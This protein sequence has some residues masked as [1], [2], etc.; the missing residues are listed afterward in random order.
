MHGGL[1]CP[2]G[3]TRR[4]NCVSRQPSSRRIVPYVQGMIALDWYEST[5]RVLRPPIGNDTTG[6]FT[7]FWLKNK[8]GQP[9]LWP[10]PN[11]TDGLGTPMY[12]FSI[13]EVQEY[14]VT[15]VAA[16]LAGAANMKGLWFDDT[17]WLA[18]NDMCGEA[19]LHVAFKPCGM[20]AK[21]RLF[22]GTIAW[23]RAVVTLLNQ[24]GQVSG[25]VDGWVDGCDVDTYI[26]TYSHT[27]TL[28]HTHTHTHTHA[29]ARTHAH[30][31][32]RSSPASTAWTHPGAWAVVRR[33]KR[34][35]LAR[36]R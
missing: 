27:H 1:A 34:L 20:E 11:P 10:S 33:A 17:D 13:P 18:C 28:S 2:P 31:R 12:N 8:S 6:A 3:A 4:T 25:W 29:R 19:G 23:K 5:R 36:S 24:F 9:L 16:P 15:R 21:D 26:S 32:C 14:F 30:T 22:N 7:H 35:S